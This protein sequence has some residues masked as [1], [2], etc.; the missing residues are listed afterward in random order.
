MTRTMGIE[1][2]SAGPG[3]LSGVR[4]VDMT[5]GLGE[6]AGRYLAELG[7]DVILVEPPGGATARRA[8]PWHEDGTSLYFATRNAGKRGIVLD[9][10]L[11]AD[12]ERLLALLGTA[13]IWLESD[14]SGHPVRRGIDPAGVA[15]RN[16]GLVIVSVTDFGHTGPYR[17]WTS[18][19]RVQLAMAGVLSRS[20]LPGLPP[21][22]PPGLLATE[23]AAYQAAWV[24]LLAYH[25]RLE[26]GLGDHIDFSVYEAVAQTFDPGFGIGARRSAVSGRPTCRAAARTPGRC[27]R[28]S[29]VRTATYGSVSSAPASGAPCGPGWENRRSSPTPGTRSSRSGGGW[30][31]ASTG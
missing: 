20:G 23:A 14:R 30:P 21:L 4:V 2:E 1:G 26:T 12:R 13:D 3:P 9:P 24:A 18:T 5:D 28:S 19:E 16:P 27:T 8:A 11:R 6:S 15:A 22:T 10:E 17:D 7:A 29:P 31:T 25:Q